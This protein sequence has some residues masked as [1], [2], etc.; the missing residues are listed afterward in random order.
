MAL[1]LAAC[2]PNPNGQGVAEFGSVQG[3]VVD[4]KTQQP[5]Q[6][7][8]VTIGGQSVSVSPASQ[9]VFRVDHVPIGT[10]SLQVYAIGYQSFQLPGIVVQKDQT[11]NIDQLIGIVST[12]GL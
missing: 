8:T 7:F 4:A 10:Q 3:R 9:G 5:I 6:Q 12:S 11:T 2:S 1:V